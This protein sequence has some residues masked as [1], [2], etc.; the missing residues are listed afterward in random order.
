MPTDDSEMVTTAPTKL[1]RTIDPV[2]IV[3][4]R[5]RRLVGPSLA[6]PSRT[7]P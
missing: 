5:T 6:D 3:W 4:I 2:R 7:E 1:E